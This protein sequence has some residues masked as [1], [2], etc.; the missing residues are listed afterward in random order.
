MNDPKALFNTKWVRLTAKGKQQMQEEY[1]KANRNPDPESHYSWAVTE[2]ID[3]RE[4]CRR[5]SHVADW[6]DK[7][8]SFLLELADK[9]A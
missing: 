9:L 6:R 7:L 1:I 3:Y 8:R 5:K 2:L 4:L